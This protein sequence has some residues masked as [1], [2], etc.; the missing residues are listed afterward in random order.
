MKNFLKINS[1]PVN[2]ANKQSLSIGL[3]LQPFTSIIGDC[4][5][6]GTA[7]AGSNQKAVAQSCNYFAGTAV[8]GQKVNLNTCIIDVDDSGLVHFI[9]YLGNQ[10][11][12]AE[13]NCKNGT[14]T[15]SKDRIVHRPQSQATQRMLDRVCSVR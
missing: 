9:Y 14:W 4:I 15:T 7:V 8:T 2:F 6:I 3:N 5:L 10:K 11:L 13:A 12:S 1:N